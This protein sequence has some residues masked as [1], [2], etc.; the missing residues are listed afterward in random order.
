MDDSSHPL[1][2]TSITTLRFQIVQRQ[3][4]DIGDSAATQDKINELSRL[5]RGCIEKARLCCGQPHTG[6][7]R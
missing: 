2:R 5:D 6:E 7:K 3:F 4:D 1:K